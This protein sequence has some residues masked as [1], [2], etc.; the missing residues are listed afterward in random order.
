MNLEVIEIP[1]RDAGL[2]QRLLVQTLLSDSVRDRKRRG[3]AILVD[4]RALNE[5]PDTVAVRLR[6]AEVA[7]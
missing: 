1:R 7:S 2:S 6:I 4:R 3:C 5:T